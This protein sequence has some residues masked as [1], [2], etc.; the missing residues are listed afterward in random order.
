[1]SET[2]TRNLGELFREA[3][4]NQPTQT[5][6]KKGQIRRTKNNKTGIE[7]VSV[8]KCPGRKQ[9]FM[10]QFASSAT[11]ER[12]IFKSVDILK[13]KNKAIKLGYKWN[14]FDETLARKTAKKAN[15]SYGE[16]I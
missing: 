15:I 2:Q 7:C 6:K 5:Q 10:Y 9:G 13:L 1:M 11:G 12:V 4:K 8:I 16:L 14:I 3:L